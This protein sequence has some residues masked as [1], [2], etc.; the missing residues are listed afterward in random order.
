[1]ANAG[2]NVGSS[3]LVATMALGSLVLWIG[4][5]A[6]WLWLA[7]RLA[8]STQPSLGLYVMVLVGIPVTMVLVGKVLARLNRAHQELRGRL[9]ERPQQAPWMKSLRGER[10]SNRDHGVLGVV[11]VWSVATAL[12]AMG[13]WFFFFAEGGGLP[14]Q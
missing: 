3:V 5:P 7:S 12:A 6:F 1:M 14:G 4:V 13:V 10:T 9:D 2:R 8:T 11:M